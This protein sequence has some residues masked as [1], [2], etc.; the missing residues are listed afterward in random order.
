MSDA[1]WH[2]QLVAINPST[3]ESS[4]NV[5]ELRYLFLTSQMELLDTPKFLG[6]LKY[7]FQPKTLGVMVVKVNGEKCDRCW[8]YSTYVGQSEVH[9]L[10]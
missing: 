2:Q 10:L 4:N 3:G 6:E 9:P 1:D 5:D 8:N 7:Q